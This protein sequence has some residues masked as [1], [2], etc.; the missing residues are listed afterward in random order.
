MNDTADVLYG[1]PAA[2]IARICQVDI[3]TARG[4]KKGSHRPP[5]SALMVLCG[6]LGVFDP[7]FQG[8]RLRDG[9][10]VSPEGWTA[11]PGEVL[12]IPLMRAQIA[13]Y[14]AEQRRVQGMVEQPEPGT[15]GWATDYMRASRD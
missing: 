1:I 7:A 11:S 9:K 3:K 4:W 10:L 8:W 15:A 13:S 2:E 5:P 12:S 14:Q 6:N